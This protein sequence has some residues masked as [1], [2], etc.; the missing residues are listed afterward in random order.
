L[1]KIN[2]GALFR[3]VVKL[4]SVVNFPALATI[5][6]TEVAWRFYIYA[7]HADFIAGA[8]VALSQQMALIAY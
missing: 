3:A 2:R 7:N 4:T 6:A 8:E 5:A 1:H